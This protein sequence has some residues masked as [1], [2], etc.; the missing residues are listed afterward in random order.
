MNQ[1][2]DQMNSRGIEVTGLLR[3]AVL[4]THRFQKINDCVDHE[5]LSNISRSTPILQTIV[6]WYQLAHQG[7]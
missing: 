1:S 4:A 7:I 2:P 6:H 3:T 5:Q